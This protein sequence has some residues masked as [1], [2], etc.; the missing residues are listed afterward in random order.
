MAGYELGV[1]TTSGDL[2]IQANGTLTV[3]GVE[4]EIQIAATAHR[5]PDGVRFRGTAPLRMTQFGIKPPTTMMGALRTSDD[6]VIHFDLV[7]APN[8]VSSAA[9]T[10]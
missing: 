1:E 2:P 6:V 9:S 4:R 7:I 5:E 3:A 8:A 10:H